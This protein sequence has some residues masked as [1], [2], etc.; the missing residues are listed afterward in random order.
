MQIVFGSI[1]YIFRNIWYVLPYAIMPAVFLALLMDYSAISEIVTG[2]FTGAPQ[3]DFL[4][5][6]SALSIV[7]IDLLSGIYTVCAFICFV[8]FLTLML[9]FAEKHMRLGKRTPGGTLS[10]FGNL[11]LSVAG[12][13]LVYLVLYEVWAV[14]LSAVLFALGAVSSPVLV[15]I[16]DAIVFLIFAF[17]LLYLASVF[18]LWLPCKQMTGFGNYNAFLYSYRMMTEVRGRLLLSLLLSF[19]AIAAVITGVSLVSDLVFRVVA[20]LLFV[21]GFLNFGIRMETVYF[22]A[23]KLDREDLIRSYREL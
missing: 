12:I 13:T 23:D 8:V 14:A 7:G 19:F 4:L 16:L 21:F 18:Y 17:A 22:S 10:Q 15:C 1:K 20:F 6:F 11:L 5:N 9:C 3:S 2:F